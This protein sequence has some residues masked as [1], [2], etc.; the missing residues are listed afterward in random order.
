MSEAIPPFLHMPSWHGAQLKMHRR[1]KVNL[2]VLDYHA[3]RP[4]YLFYM[5]LGGHQGWSLHGSKEMVLS[6]PLV[7]YLAIQTIA[8]VVM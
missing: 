3:V 7:N 1:V 8:I 2:F 6:L 4:L 5:R